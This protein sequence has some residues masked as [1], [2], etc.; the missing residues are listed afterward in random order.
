MLASLK[1]KETYTRYFK[2]FKFAFYCLTH[3]M[4]GFWDITHEKRGSMAVA[5]SILILTLLARICRLQFTSF[6]FNKVYWPEINIFMYLASVLFPLALW[7]VANWA[8]T[9]LFDGKARLPQ[10]YMATCYCLLPYP[11]FQFPLIILSNMVTVDEGAFYGVISAV[12][13]ALC[14][15][16]ILIAMSQIH[17][18]TM[19]K[20]LLFTVASLFGMLVIIF[21]LLLFFS[22][23]SQGIAYFVSIVKEILFRM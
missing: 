17:E 13:L 2:N 5:N 9:T 12:S 10:I 19:R 20:T 16:L 11:L 15:F 21:I 18:Y 22:M 6:I 23:I 14:A 1:K 8:W 3:P 7:C 4:D